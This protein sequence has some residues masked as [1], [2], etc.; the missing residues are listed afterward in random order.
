MDRQFTAGGK[1]E[2]PCVGVDKCEGLRRTNRRRSPPL[3]HCQSCPRGD[4]EATAEDI[5][6]E[7]EA[8]DVVERLIAE[9]RSGRPPK[10][11]ELAPLEWELMMLHEDRATANERACI[12]KI[13]NIESNFEE[14]LKMLVAAKK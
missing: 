7:Q 11:S 6:F 4:N 3:T 2:K 12:G 14:Y 10:L 5:E 9:K 8:C 1:D 13:V